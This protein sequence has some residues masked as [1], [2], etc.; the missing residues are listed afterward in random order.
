MTKY[1]I[2]FKY[3]SFCCIL[4]AHLR[5]LVKVGIREILLLGHPEPR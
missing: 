5:E 2:S 3:G 1:K 4:Q